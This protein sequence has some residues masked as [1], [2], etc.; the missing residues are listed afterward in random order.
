MYRAT[1]ICIYTALQSAEILKI[2]AKCY[3]GMLQYIQ[4]IK[5]EQL[6]LI[7]CLKVSDSKVIDCKKLL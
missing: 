7:V 5:F 2:C 1:F 6:V 4:R 3:A